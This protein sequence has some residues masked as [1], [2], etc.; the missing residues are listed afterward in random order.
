MTEPVAKEESKGDGKEEEIIHNF[1]EAELDKM[2]YYWDKTAYPVVEYTYFKDEWLNTPSNSS[3]NA[4]QDSP[5]AKDQ[6]TLPESQN[7][8]G[9]KTRVDLGNGAENAT[10]TYFDL[11]TYEEVQIVEFYAPWCP[12]CQQFKREYI[13]VAREVIRRS[14]GTK[15]SFKAIS[16][17]MYREVCQTYKIKGFPTVMG[18]PAG[19]NIEERGRDLNALGD[20]KFSAQK[21]ADELGITLAHEAKSFFTSK[22]SDSKDQ[23]DHDERIAKQSMEAAELKTSWHH[24]PSTIND[25]YHN[26]ATSLSFALK[27]G[28]YLVDGET[29]DSRRAL[30]LQDF[31]D[32]VDWASPQSWQARTGLV[33]ELRQTFNEKVISGRAGLVKIVEEHQSMHVENGLWG[34]IQINRKKHRIGLG[35]EAPKG[36][37]PM[38][39]NDIFW[40][41]NVWTE[42]CTHSQRGLGFTCGLWDLFHM[43]SLGA[44][45]P[46]H[47]IYGWRSGY[48]TSPQHVGETIRNFIALFFPCD[49]CRWNFLD[50]YDN[51][52]HRHCKRLITSMPA[53]LHDDEKITPEIAGREL[54][55]W[56]WEVHNAINIRLMRE[57]AERENRIVS[58]EEK[59]AGQFPTM[60]LCNKCWKDDRMEKWD[61]AAVYDFLKD[62][63]SK[64]VADSR[65]LS[66]LYKEGREPGHSHREQGT[67]HHGQMGWV[68]PSALTYG[69][70]KKIEDIRF[71]GSH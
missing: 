49:V 47:Q 54:A 65:F 44:G 11:N 30:V 45:I 60:L 2:M 17:E 32:L 42:A 58:D 41:N 37:A 56:L 28:V 40:A 3:S 68:R 52:G 25:R 29:L 62:W 63:P 34:D 71:R 4:T 21:I 51:C 24:E 57:S 8:D 9:H 36:K 69:R 18:F 20:T 15:V 23:K 6:K 13:Q 61:K 38:T 59:L 7:G 66:V 43:L 31:L 55:L 12:H 39:A 1:T 5:T 10:A 64:E 16:C 35:G 33:Q 22:Y 70:R 48:L 19:F 50:M 14:L 26:A 67:A 53:L 46:V 27:T